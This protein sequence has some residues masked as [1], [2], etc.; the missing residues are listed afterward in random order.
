MP[1]KK[2]EG[3]EIFSNR[4][5]TASC[6]K[7]TIEPKRKQFLT[8]NIHTMNGAITKIR[9]ELRQAFQQIQDVF[10]IREDILFYKPA[11]E[12][13]SINEVLEHV[14]LANYFLLRIVNKQV[15]KDMLVAKQTKSGNTTANYSLNM[16]KLKA[17]E[18][19]GSYVWVPKRYTEPA[20]E[21][22]LLQLR[23]ALHD[24]M[25]ESLTIL[26]SKQAMEAIAETYEAG[27]VDALHYLYFMVKHIQR[28]LEQIRKVQT[29]FYQSQNQSSFVDS[30]QIRSSFC[31][32]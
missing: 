19:T 17:M 22:P 23:M 2:G 21:V 15:A 8:I 10:A 3:H 25:V 32:N 14:L 9:I 30:R 12:G 11:D 16:T 5:D 26:N 7:Q 13:W 6:T 31:L 4:A 29:A 28:H 20:G 18:V 27:K 1:Q 24:Q